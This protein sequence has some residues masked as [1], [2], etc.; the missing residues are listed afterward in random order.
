[1]KITGSIQNVKDSKTKSLRKKPYR[2]QIDYI[3][4]RNSETIRI[5]DSKSSTNKITMSDLKAVIMKI[6]IVFKNYCKKCKIQ[7]IGYRRLR[8]AANVQVN[9]KS[10]ILDRFNDINYEIIS[11]QQKCNTITD[12]LKESAKT[13]VSY[14]ERSKRSEYAY[15]IMLSD[16]QRNIIIRN[17]RNHQ[18]V[19]NHEIPDELTEHNYLQPT[20]IQ[21]FNTQM[22]YADDLSKPTSYHN[23]IRRYEH[24]AEENLTNIKN[25]HKKGQKVS[26]NKTE[27]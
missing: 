23:D 8:N 4:V 2:N 16:M 27:N 11:S 13:T 3:L 9:Y 20:Q 21:H 12:I 25:E 24:N 14:I 10:I 7:Q 17:Q 1:M 18:S 6:T 15:I 26:K 5:T 22:E 19:T